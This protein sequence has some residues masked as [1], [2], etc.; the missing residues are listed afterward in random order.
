MRTDIRR[1]VHRS[2]LDILAA[3]SLFIY[4]EFLLAV[5]FYGRIFQ[6]TEKTSNIKI[7][8]GLFK[9]ILFILFHW[10]ILYFSSLKAENKTNE[11]FICT[12]QLPS[13]TY[14]N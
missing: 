6:H 10:L 1:N 14:S 8:F 3:F 2:L 13:T 9:L 12:H 7:W 11:K 4:M 5:S